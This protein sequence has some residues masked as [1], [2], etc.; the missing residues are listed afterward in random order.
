MRQVAGSMRHLIYQKLSASIPIVVD[1][2]KERLIKACLMLWR[3]YTH[4]VW[5]MTLALLGASMQ[6]DTQHDVGA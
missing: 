2:S 5:S 6:I 4:S 3:V 1:R